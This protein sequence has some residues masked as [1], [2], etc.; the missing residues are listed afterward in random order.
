M[1][2]MPIYADQTFNCMTAVHIGIARHINKLNVTQSTL[3]KLIVE[4]I[5]NQNIRI[6]IRKYSQMLSDRPMTSAVD[7][8]AFV[9]AKLLRHNG[10]RIDFRRKGIDICW[11][12]YCFGDF[13][14]LCFVCVIFMK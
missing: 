13:I 1:L 9:I 6:N 4:T 3:T 7:E 5:N 2:I 14:I 10:N 12:T 8:A 11:F